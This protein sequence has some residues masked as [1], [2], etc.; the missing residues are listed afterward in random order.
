MK[1][2][3]QKY[4]LVRVAKDLGKSMRHFTADCDAIVLGTY[5]QLC[6]G[7]DVNNYS[8][9]IKD[10]GE[11]SWYYES[12]LT[13]IKTNQPK[14]LAMWKEAD[15]ARHKQSGDLD[16]I[17]S[18]GKEIIKNGAEGA[19]IEALAQCLEVTNLW[20]MNGEGMNYY[21]NAITILQIAKPWLETNDK[22][23]W[24]EFVKNGKE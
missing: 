18:H 24:L 19:T 5:K 3:Y 4:D 12:Q 10:E 21:L 23:G 6:G 7:T 13:L 11:T 16:W 17:F 20:G 2:K 1:Q 9:Y 8:L 22:K 15:E 14:I